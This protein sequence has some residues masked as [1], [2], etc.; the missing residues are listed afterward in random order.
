MW[1]LGISELQLSRTPYCS[2]RVLHVSCYCGIFYWSWPELKVLSHLCV[3]CLT[4]WIREEVMCHHARPR[5]G[6]KVTKRCNVRLITNLL[7]RRVCETK[8]RLQDHKTPLTPPPFPSFDAS[9][10]YFAPLSTLKYFC[11]Y[12][13]LKK[14][15]WSMCVH[16]LKWLDNLPHPPSFSV[17]PYDEQENKAFFLEK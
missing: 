10:A 8:I 15:D 14:C 17:F 3:P 7:F 16:I 5:G 6:V 12:C 11:M 1:H 9:L 2:K 13:L 4:A